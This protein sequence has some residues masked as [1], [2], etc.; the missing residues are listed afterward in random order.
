MKTNIKY[1]IYELLASVIL[2]PTF[3][4]FL[5]VSIEFGHW[6]LIF[7]VAFLCVEVFVLYDAIKNIQWFDVK[8]GNITVHS[9]FGIVKSV[10]LNQIKG[11][12][13]INAVI[14][15]SKAWEFKRPHIVLC[16]T[17]SVKK[18]EITDAYNRKKRKYIII[19][20]TTETELWIQTEYQKYCN[21]P[22]I[23]K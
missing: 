6:L 5:I 14:F 10:P 21:Q 20:Y 17:K 11:A 12:F 2:F 8:N 3:L 19:P 16:L 7:W 23:I 1:S 18:S 4:I 15:W 22:L 13:S 9:P